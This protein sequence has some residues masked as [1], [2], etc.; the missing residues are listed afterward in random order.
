MNSAAP[1]LPPV[2]QAHR[3]FSM[4]IHSGL[5]VFAGLIALLDSCSTELTPPKPPTPVAS[6][7]IVPESTSMNVGQIAQLTA[8]AKDALGKALPGRVVTWAT[9]NA[10]VA[11]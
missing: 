11:T 7:L 8:T 9:D 1:P 3:A 6:V 4:R 5:T 2:A 10:L